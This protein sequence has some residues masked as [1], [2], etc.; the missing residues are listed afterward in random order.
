MY[1]HLHR[2]EGC[3]HE[4]CFVRQGLSRSASDEDRAG[5]GHRADD[6]GRPAVRPATPPGEGG[7]Q[8]SGCGSAPTAHTAGALGAWTGL[9]KR[10]GLGL[11]SV[12]V[13]CF[14]R[15]H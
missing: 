6:Q 10:A 5:P 11:G 9:R 13:I 14:H 4:D 7:H 12:Y 8:G 2:L 15:F 3:G 1:A